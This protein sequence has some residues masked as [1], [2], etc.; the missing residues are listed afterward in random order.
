MSVTRTA[1]VAGKPN[2]I[3]KIPEHVV[4]LLNGID[5]KCEGSYTDLRGHSKL[6][7]K[8]GLEVL[9]AQ[10]LDQVPLERAQTR[11]A[12]VV[13]LFEA[14]ASLKSKIETLYDRAIF[15][16]LEDLDQLTVQVELS[17]PRKGQPARWLSCVL[18][19]NGQPLDYA[20]PSHFEREIVEA[21]QSKTVSVKAGPDGLP[22]MDEVIEA[23]MDS[24]KEGD[25]ADDTGPK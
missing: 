13:C 14:S 5:H 15:V 12:I 7:N 2:K 6:H 20:L 24:V 23:V 4:F 18:K 1:F 16:K 19:V 22:D 10:K 21:P 17:R 9:I 11:D 3:P 25:N 8:G